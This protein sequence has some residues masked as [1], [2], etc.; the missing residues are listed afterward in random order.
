MMDIHLRH[1]S[2]AYTRDITFVKTEYNNYIPYVAQNVA[3][4]RGP[5][6]VCDTVY[7]HPLYVMSLSWMSAFFLVALFVGRDGNPF[8]C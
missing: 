7:I 5:Y 8:L 4:D 1:F 3:V 6:I 2:I